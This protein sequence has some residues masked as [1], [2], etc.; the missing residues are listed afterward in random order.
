MTELLENVELAD[1]NTFRLPAKTRYYA[2]FATP[3]DLKD[4][5]G[6]PEVM[7][8][9]VFVLGGGSNLVL[10]KDYEG[11]MLHSVDCSVRI[12]RED[13]AWVDV[14]VGAG[15]DWSEFVL[16]AVKNKWS[17]IENLS[18]IPG[19][20][21][22]AAVQNIGAYGMEVKDAIAS[23]TCFDPQSQFVVRI[24]RKDLAYGYRT[25]FFKSPEG[26]K[27][28]VLSVTFHLSKR[29]VPNLK[30][31]ALA[32][33]LRSLTGKMITP[34]VVAG[35]VRE[36]RKSKL[37][38]LKRLGSAGSFFKNPILS[39]MHGRRVL[40]EHPAIPYHTMSSGRIKVSAA[41]LIAHGRVHG[42]KCGQA[43]VFHKAPLVI[44]NS[45]HAT[46][47]DVM[48]VAEAVRDGIKKRYSIILQ[49]E[50]VIL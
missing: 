22:G 19:S 14:T 46:A 49:Y 39:R 34:A 36:I 2:E 17:R 10:T 8:L 20:V 50:V 15:K 30:Y 31:Q 13:D 24:E 29:F 12:D 1:K 16:D 5:L 33:R 21:G 47:R 43:H 4:L 9:P 3:E 23:V 27:L 6:R 42:K 41:W 38:G 26:S 11:L 44:V 40:R 25:S 18:G 37:P 35:Q 45:G 28:I 32:E 7:G 48:A